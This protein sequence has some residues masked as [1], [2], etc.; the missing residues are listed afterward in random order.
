MNDPQG[1]RTA[2]RGYELPGIGRGIFY[3]L[4]EHNPGFD[5]RI[6]RKEARIR[7]SFKP[8]FHPGG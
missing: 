4:K 6:S 5:G 8:L 1:S 3:S 7:S 2:S